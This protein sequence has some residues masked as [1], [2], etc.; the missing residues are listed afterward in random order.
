MID[1]DDQGYSEQELVSCHYGCEL[2]EREKAECRMV[3]ILISW[4]R[5]SGDD[6]SRN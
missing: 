6:L 2:V 3:M 5:S 1:E 4:E